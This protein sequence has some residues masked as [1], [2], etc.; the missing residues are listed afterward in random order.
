MDDLIEKYGKGTCCYKA[1]K[2]VV[3]YFN[4]NLVI[5]GSLLVEYLPGRNFGCNARYFLYLRIFFTNVISKT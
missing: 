5:L 3:K 1:R 2:N 4:V